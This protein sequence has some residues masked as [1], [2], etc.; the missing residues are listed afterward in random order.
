MHS[1]VDLPEAT[2]YPEEVTW[3]W[4][5]ARLRVELPDLVDDFLVEF[6]AK[7]PYPDDQVPDQDIADTARQTFD[8]LIRRLRDEPD[9]PGAAGVMERLAARRAQQGVPLSTFL[10]AVRI[11]FRVMW[12]RL[13]RIA[14][15]EGNTVLAQNVMHLLDTVDAYVDSLREAYRAEVERIDRTAAAHR[16][17]MVMRLFNGKPI[18]A[19]ELEL[20]AGRLRMRALAEYE[21]V[22]VMGEGI[23]A[24]IARYGSDP[25]V[26]IFESASAM[27]LFREQQGR[28]QW[29]KDAHECGGYVGGVNGLAGVYAAGRLALEIA[30]NAPPLPKIL[31]TEDEVWAAVARSHLLDVFPGRTT[32]LLDS[33]SELAEHERERVVEAVQTYLVSG[34]IKETA[35]RLYCHRNTVINRLRTFGERTGFDPTVPREAAWIFVALA[36]T[37]GD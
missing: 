22:A 9:P 15:T 19:S 36:P 3:D 30:A 8:L 2:G 35:E 32:A 24:M 25:R 5:L 14:G 26:G 12:L 11:D 7:E 10:R 17:R 34:S 4:L 16:H 20:I 21:V 33:L 18:S 37:V 27:I 1:D 29:R 6:R 13:Q 23:T 31:A 28:E